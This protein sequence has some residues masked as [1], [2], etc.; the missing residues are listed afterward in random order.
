MYSRFFCD[1]LQ[2]SSGKLAVF[3]TRGQAKA[4]SSGFPGLSAIIP[5]YNEAGRIGRAILDTK[6]VLGDE[7]EIIVVDDGSSDE[8]A[9]EALEAGARVVRHDRNRGKGAAVKTGAL[10]SK[11]EWILVLDADLSTHPREIQHFQPYFDHSDLVIGSRRADG[12]F[13]PMQQPL[14]RVKAGQVFNWLMRTMCGLPYQDTQ[15]GFKVYRMELCRPLFQALTT[16]GWSFDVELLLR[17]RLA[18]AR[19]TEL[20]VTWQHVDGSKVKIR[21]TLAILIE[22]WRLR[23]IIPQDRLDDSSKN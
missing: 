16:E 21:H 6:C 12:S 1:T 4:M 10:A 2:N 15:C 9:Q 3:F 20:P 11:S 14:Y 5:A 17:A 23:R 22:L 18:D 7:A 8:T 13:I 19:I